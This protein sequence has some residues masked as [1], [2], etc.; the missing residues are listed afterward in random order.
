[1][2]A[3]NPSRRPRRLAGLLMVLLVLA[4]CGGL[5]VHLFSNDQD[6]LKE[7][8]LQGRG[9]DK[10]LVIPVTGILSDIRRPGLFHQTPSAVEAVASRLKRAEK[11]S[12]VRAVVLKINT[13]GG[14]ITA[15]DILYHA[16]SDY[17]A[18]T[19]AVVVAV[20]MDLATSGG[21]YMALPADWIMAHPTTVTGSVGAILMTPRVTG[22]MEKLGIGVEAVKSG[23]NKDMGSPFRTPTPEET[24]MLQDLTS[25]LG[26]RFAD[27][28]AKRRHLTP[29]ALNTVKTA[30]I[31]LAQDALNLHLIDSI[32]YM[33]D[34]LKR[35]KA[36]ADISADAQ[37][38]VYRREQRP[39]DTVYSTPES[40][41]AG[42]SLIDLGPLDPLG[43]LE[44]GFYYLWVPGARGL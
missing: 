32:G 28:V 26:A 33:D 38:V 4:G 29:E 35:A 20:F 30:R 31:F 7:Y 24:Q 16:I 9:R 27:L 22:L 1:M 10:V 3:P 12:R 6:P 17:K 14:S 41:A 25:R 39:D 13:P 36:L 23:R 44:T 43:Q 2:S 11:D 34:A 5:H 40:R 8:V 42:A 18:R 15:S 37:V 19:K 21:Y